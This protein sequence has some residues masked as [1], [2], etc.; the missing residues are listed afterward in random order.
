MQKQRVKHI[1]FDL[2]NTL[3]DHRG[4][5]EATLLEMFETYEITK[6]YNLEF[7]EWHDIFY[8]ENELLWQQIR[9]NKIS[10][11]KLRE[12]RFKVPFAHFGI[13]NKALSE[14]F[15]TVY[16][17]KLSHKEKPVEGALELINYLYPKYKIHIITNGFVEVSQAKVNNLGIN[18][19][20][21][22]LTCADELEIRKPDSRIFQ[23]AMDKAK[24]TKENSLIIGDD[25]IADV[26]GG[27]DFGWQAIFFDSLNEGFTLENVAV[28]KNMIEIKELF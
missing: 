9:D 11:E 17:E 21:L 26:I 23:H 13:E 22:T 5:S 7:D 12:L 6:K 14:E 2:D 16:L 27:T 19:K 25:W 8:E 24:S 1:F 4:N 15:E 28:V 20:V 18:E 10:K 3:W